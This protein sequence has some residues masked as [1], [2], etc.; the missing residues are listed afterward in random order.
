VASD[1]HL[2]QIDAAKGLEMTEHAITL[3]VMPAGCGDG[4]LV[5]CPV[6]RQT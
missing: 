2:A 3:E 1:G 6:G 5:Q 4:L